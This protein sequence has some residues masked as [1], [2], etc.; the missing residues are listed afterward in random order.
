MLDRVRQIKDE[1]ELQVMRETAQITDAALAATVKQIRRGMTA[2]D[3]TIEVEY[4]FR[5]AGAEG[6]SFPPT[7]VCLEPGADVKTHSPDTVIQSGSVLSFDM[8]AIY[9][10][11]TSDFGRTIFVGEPSA[12]ALRSYASLAK[13][14]QTLTEQL[15]DGNMTAEEAA[16]FVVASIAEDGLGKYHYHPGLG[17]G[18]GLVDHEDPWVF[19]GIKD[20][21]RKGMCLAL[22][23]KI[24][25]PGEFYMRI[26]DVVAVGEDRSEFLTQY[27][28]DPQV[29]D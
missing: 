8:G 27:S 22:E 24:H 19:P 3:V 25:V 16:Q 17:H 23:P 13:S 21:I 5:K 7:V 14:L 10:R 4:Q 15:G 29:I 9:K 28:H 12:L 20:K 11:Y 18:I 1:F 6:L 26:E 2:R